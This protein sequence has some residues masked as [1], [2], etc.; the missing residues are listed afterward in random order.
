M[1]II[2]IYY[3]LILCTCNLQIVSMVRLHANFHSPHPFQGFLNFQ[4]YFLRAHF[5]NTTKF[6]AKFHAFSHKIGPYS[7]RS[8]SQPRL[9]NFYYLL[10]YLRIC[11][12]IHSK[13][14]TFTY[15]FYA[16][17]LLIINF[18]LVISII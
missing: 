17:L 3:I 13:L 2:L 7:D 10:F 15:T 9:A 6:C 5:R 11:T 1:Y 18:G 16:I 14:N 8:L 12:R 4:K